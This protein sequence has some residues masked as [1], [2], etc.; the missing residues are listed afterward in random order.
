MA[1][2]ASNA[3]RDCVPKIAKIVMPIMP[4]MAQRSHVIG[5]CICRK[6]ISGMVMTSAMASWLLSR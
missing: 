3:P 2:M 4:P 5:V 1:T 6:R